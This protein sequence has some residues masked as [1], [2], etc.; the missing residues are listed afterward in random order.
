M[1]STVQKLTDIEA[2]SKA[3]AAQFAANALEAREKLSQECVKAAEKVGELIDADASVDEDGR[4]SQNPA[5]LRLQLE[6]AK[7]TLHLNSIG[8]ED[9]KKS[10]VVI[11]ITNTQAA[12]IEQFAKLEGV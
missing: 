6:A 12:K 11:N 2:R 3:F 8:S 5:I 9:E 1:A 7:L 10:Q 4:P